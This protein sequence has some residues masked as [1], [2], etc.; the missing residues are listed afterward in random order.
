MLVKLFEGNAV[1]PD[2]VKYI[3]VREEQTMTA[4][5]Q[6]LVSLVVLR[7]E[8]NVDLVVSACDTWEE[9]TKIAEQCADRINKGLGVEDSSSDDSSSSDS[10]FDFGSS[11]DDSSSDDSSSDDSSSDDSGSTD[12]DEL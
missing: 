1:N 10:G 7:L 9:A 8:D 3:T 5:G 11:D 6:K 4:R 2:N 12:S